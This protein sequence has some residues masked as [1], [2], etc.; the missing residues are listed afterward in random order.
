[1]KKWECTVCGYIHEGDEPPDV[2]PICGAGKEYFVELAEEQVEAG[3]ETAETVSGAAASPKSLQDSAEPSVIAAL[4]MKFHL[5]PIMAHTPNGVLPMALTFLFLGSVFGLAG[6]EVAAFF[7]FVFVLLAMPVVILTGYLE[8]QNRYKGIKTK[9]FGLKIAASVVVL[10]TL[11]AMV[12]W[13]IADPG[14][15]A[16]ANRWIYLLVGLV[17]VGA[18]GLAG[19][20]GGKLVFDTRDR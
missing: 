12:V 8:W 6:F 9:I 2:C 3:Q 15:A 10:T 4:V 5:H 1:M 7:S 19:H 17:M 14:V 13:R 16:S 18:V 20:M 11:T